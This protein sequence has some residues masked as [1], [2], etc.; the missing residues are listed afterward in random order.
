METT[1]CSM[2]RSV[3]RKYTV[4]AKPSPSRPPQLKLTTGKKCRRHL[5][6]KL[7]GE[8]REVSCFIDPREEF[9]EGRL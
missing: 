2:P 7:G 6:V 1:G 8:G 3:A 9:S 4:G 5:R